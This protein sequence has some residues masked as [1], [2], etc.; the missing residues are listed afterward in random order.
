MTDNTDEEHLDNPTNNQ[1]ENVPDELAP[2]TDTESINSTQETENMEVHHHAH[3]PV[4]PHHKKNWKSYF[5]EFLMLF[6]AVFCGFLAEYQLEHVVEHNREK[7]YIESMVEELNT[8]SIRLSRIIDLNRQQAAGFDS[9]LMNVYH[10]PYTDSSIKTLYYLHKKYSTVIYSMLFSK[11]TITQLKN[12]GGLR[13][14]R[15]KAAADSII[16]YDVFS[17]RIEAQDEG[18]GYSGKL[19]F[20][21]SVKL[22]DSEYF[23]NYNGSNLKEILNSFP[24]LSL[25]TNDEKLIKEYASLAMFKRNIIKSN[26]NQ[27]TTLQNRIPGIKQYLEQEYHLN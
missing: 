1:L 6:L 21:L 5:W 15:K 16:N 25:L 23:I 20:E 22:F 11:A 24:K 9:L 13:L 19:L 10:K 27:L 26:I 18:L 7:Q 17:Q 8:D 4:A 12:S 2:I 3:D 14:I